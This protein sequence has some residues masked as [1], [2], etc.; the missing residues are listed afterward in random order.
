M[1]LVYGDRLFQDVVLHPAR[2]PL[3]ILPN[4]LTEICNYRGS[5]GSELGSKRIGVDLLVQMALLGFDLELVG[6]AFTHIG[7]EKFPDS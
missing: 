7:D 5:V 4:V 2:H 1:H 3:C 6:L